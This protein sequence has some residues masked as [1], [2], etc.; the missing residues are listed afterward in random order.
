MPL[1]PFVTAATRVCVSMPLRRLCR[2]LGPPRLSLALLDL[3]NEAVRAAVL[4]H[5]LLRSRRASAEVTL[6][7]NILHLILFL[8]PSLA[9]AACSLFTTTS[10]FPSAI[11]RQSYFSWLAQCLTALWCRMPCVV[12]RSRHFAICPVPTCHLARHGALPVVPRGLPDASLHMHMRLRTKL[13][14][15]HS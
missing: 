11:F 8:F 4:P 2:V 12:A 1:S 14:Y 5:A 3:Y 13:P 6:H 7:A 15:Q 9:P 10:P